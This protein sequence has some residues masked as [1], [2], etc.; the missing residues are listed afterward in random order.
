VTTRAMRAH[1]HSTN[2]SCSRATFWVTK[3]AVRTHAHSTNSSRSRATFWVTKYA[4]HRHIQLTAATVVPHLGYTAAVRTQKYCTDV[5]YSTGYY[6]RYDVWKAG[7]LERRHSCNPL[8]TPHC[9]PRASFGT[10]PYPREFL[11][12]SPTHVK[13]H[14]VSQG[15]HFRTQLYQQHELSTSNTG[16]ESLHRKDLWDSHSPSGFSQTESP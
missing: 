9:V 10:Q 14:T 13:C 11:E 1:A 12:H 15:L 4:V 7:C 6:S 16:C 8:E 3:Y 5:C 2:S